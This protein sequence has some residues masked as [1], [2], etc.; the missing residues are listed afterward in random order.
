MNRYLV[1]LVAVA[2]LLIGGCATPPQAPVNFAPAALADAN[3]KVGVVMTVV[4]KPDTSF[5]GASCLLCIAAASAMHSSLTDATRTWATEDIAG[6]GK[7]LADKMLLRG[8]KV[9]YFPAPVNL[10]QLPDA[11]AEGPNKARKDFSP[12]KAQLGVDRLV[13]INV[14]FSG[15]TRSFSAYFPTSEPQAIVSG[16]AFMV[17]LNDNVYEWFEPFEIL[18]RA[19]GK[20]DE[21]PKYPGL[22]NAYFQAIEA[23]R[24][25]LYLPVAKP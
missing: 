13:V 21:P 17:N 9:T 23:A 14:R 7:G 3:S 18:R 20:W 22:A 8:M 10:Q 6:F 4:A 1:T 19:E 24:D 12:L 2:G 15:V 16:E 5:P 11:K 25:R